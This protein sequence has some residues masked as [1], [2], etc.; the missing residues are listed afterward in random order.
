MFVV[1]DQRFSNDRDVVNSLLVVS[2]IFWLSRKVYGISM[3]LMLSFVVSS[4]FFLG[5]GNSHGDE[6]FDNV[7]DVADSI[8]WIGC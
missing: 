2:N 8:G 7:N 6:T 5:N 1:E 3:E 4:N